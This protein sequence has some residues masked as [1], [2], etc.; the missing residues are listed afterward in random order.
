[1]EIIDTDEGWEIHV[2]VSQTHQVIDAFRQAG[3]PTKIELEPVQGGAGE[4]ED[5][6]VVNKG[7]SR[8][9]IEKVLA[10]I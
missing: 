10:T 7:I 5:Y 1:M 4:L 3:F 2:P 9:E 6:F 8:S